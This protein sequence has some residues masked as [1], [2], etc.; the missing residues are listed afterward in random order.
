MPLFEIRPCSFNKSLTFCQNCH[1][2]LCVCLCSLHDSSVLESVFTWIFVWSGSSCYGDVKKIQGRGYFIYHL[3]VVRAEHRYTESLI[4]DNI[5]TWQ[6]TNNC[7]CYLL[8]YFSKQNSTLRL[9]LMPRGMPSA[10]LVSEAP[11]KTH[12]YSVHDDI[13]SSG[14]ICKSSSSSS[15][16]LVW[17]IS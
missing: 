13:M 17:I 15:W 2:L 10:W 3:W 4:R 1:R 5:K 9:G 7:T 16:R 6:L 8:C 11:V 14:A 12:Y